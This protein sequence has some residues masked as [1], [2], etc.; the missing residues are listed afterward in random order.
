MTG[1]AFPDRVAL[2]AYNIDIHRIRNCTYPAYMEDTSRYNILPYFI[3]LR[4]LTNRDVDNLI[5]AGKCISQSFLVN[6][7]TR[8]H[9]IEFSTGQAAGVAASYFT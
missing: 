7:A 9:P 2:G 4:A 1:K 6:S 5:V 3:P 8:L